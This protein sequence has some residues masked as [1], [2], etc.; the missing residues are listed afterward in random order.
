[1][2]EIWVASITTRF[3]N[4]CYASRTEEGILKQLA[5]FCREW[6]HDAKR[7]GAGEMPGLDT[8]D[9]DLVETYFEYVD[10]EF[11]ATEKVTLND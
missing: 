1:M 7:M 10:G 3:G 4:Q 8:A 6:W 2:P 11:Y 5:E 9:I